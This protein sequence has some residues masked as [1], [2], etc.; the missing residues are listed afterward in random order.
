MGHVLSGK[1]FRD[2]NG[3]FIRVVFGEIAADVEQA[4]RF[5]DNQEIRAAVKE[6]PGLGRYH[7]A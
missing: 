2:V 6:I 1:E 5:C 7:G 4:T 3:F